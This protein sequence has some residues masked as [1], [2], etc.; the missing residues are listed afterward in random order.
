[1]KK[2]HFILTIVAVASVGV[3][4]FAAYQK[5]QSPNH[6]GSEMIDRSPDNYL[7]GANKG[8]K[9]NAVNQAQI[10]IKIDDFVYKTSHLTIKKGT[11]VIWTN[12]GQARHNVVS[13][14]NS[15]KSGLNSK[16]LS[17]GQ[18]YR[19]VFSETGTYQY[20]C[21]PHPTQMKGIIRVI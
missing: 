3:L 10:T 14:S 11:E 20:F 16:L 17:N 19:H 5:Y 21:S 12:Q 13:A 9:I 15:P 7:K 6:S 18:S 1:M 8:Q 2:T 4:G